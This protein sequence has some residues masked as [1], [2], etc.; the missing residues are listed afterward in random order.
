MKLNPRLI[1]LLVVFGGLLVYL[2]YDRGIIGGGDAELNVFDLV[3]GE[4][5]TQNFADAS[6]IRKSPPIREINWMKTWD[7]DPFFY[8]EAETT[9]A[10]G[11]SLIS[12][13]LGQNESIRFNLTGITW[14]GNEG[15]ALINGSVLKEGDKISGY[16]VTRIAYD[17]VILRRGTNI[18]RIPL[19]D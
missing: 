4:T 16:Q 7:A 6:T 17:H 13:I 18:V 14:R 8:A 3:S 9:E 11:T 15:A 1:V 19:N 5:P 12:S 2:L 10:G